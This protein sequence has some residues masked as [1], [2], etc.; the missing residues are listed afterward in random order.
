MIDVCWVGGGRGRWLDDKQCPEIASQLACLVY[1]YTC[2][3]ASSVRCRGKQRDV[4]LVGVKECVVWTVRSPP[5]TNGGGAGS[6]AVECPPSRQL[7]K[8]DPVPA[9]G[10]GLWT[11]QPAPGQQSLVSSLQNLLRGWTNALPSRCYYVSQK[12]QTESLK[13]P[14][15]R[16]NYSW[17]LPTG[18]SYRTTRNTNVPHHYLSYNP[19]TI[20]AVSSP[21]WK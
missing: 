14:V 6:R 1:T 12:F 15:T 21:K 5:T 4:L 3:R 7:R 19:S 18:W 20:S 13:L 2:C 17:C 8:Y 16:D 10:T 11:Q 9:T